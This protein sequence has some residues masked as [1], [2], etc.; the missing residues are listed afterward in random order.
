M[1]QQQHHELTLTGYLDQ[2]DSVSLLPVSPNTVEHLQ[3][4]L[5]NWLYICPI[6]HF[7]LDLQFK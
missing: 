3:T 7:L 6:L 5:K 1:F 2:D 4:V